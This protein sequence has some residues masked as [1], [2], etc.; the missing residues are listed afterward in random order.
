[1]SHLSDLD[2]TSKQSTRWQQIAAVPEEAFEAYIADGKFAL[3]SGDQ[4]A[5]GICA[6]RARAACNR[7]TISIGLPATPESSTAPR[8]LYFRGGTLQAA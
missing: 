5:A 6:M 4:P 8:R 1:M 2:V 7:C 3:V